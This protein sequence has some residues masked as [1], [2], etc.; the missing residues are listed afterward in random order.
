[1]IAHELAH[2]WFGDFVTCKDWSHIW[3]NEGFATYYDLLYDE[4]KNGRDSMLYDLYRPPKRS[5]QRPTTPSRSFVANYDN[6]NNNSAILPIQGRVGFCTCCAAEL[7]ED[8][9]RR[10]IKTYLERHQFGN[11]VTE[12]L[13]AVFEEFSGRLRPVFRS[14]GLSRLATGHWATYSWDEKAKLAKISIEQK[15]KLSED[16]LL[17]NFPLTIRFKSKAGPV[18]RT[19]TVKEKA[20]DFYFP[21]HGRAGSRAD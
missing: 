2:Q 20:E 9:Y 13:N 12:D 18:D 15:Q 19:I 21:A 5:R 6:P 4:H 14:M 3:L 17:F 8:L 10:C 16:V 11:V 1:M 7:G